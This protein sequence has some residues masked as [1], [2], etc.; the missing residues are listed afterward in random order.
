[1]NTEEQASAL[2]PGSYRVLVVEDEPLMRSIIVQLAR[3]DGYEVF[4]ISLA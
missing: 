1:M 4:E 3:S 2:E